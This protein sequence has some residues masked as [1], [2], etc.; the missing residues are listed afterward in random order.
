MITSW[1][2]NMDITL[3]KIEQVKDRTGVSYKEAKEAL[4]S[5]D[6]SVVDA[7][8]AIEESTEENSKVKE[9]AEWCAN[10]IVDKVKELVKKGNVSKVVIKREDEVIL[11]VPVTFGIIGVALA[12][13]AMLIASVLALG[14]KCVVEIVKD[15]GSIIDVSEMVNKTFDPDAANNDGAEE[16]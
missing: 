7:I 6:G 13:V 12:P 16:N 4:E 5:A 11:R 3:E 1:Q 10:K 15:D 8:I 14:A 9:N 2:E